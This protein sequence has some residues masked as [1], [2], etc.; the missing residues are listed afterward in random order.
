[1]KQIREM[2]YRAA[3]IGCGVIGSSIDEGKEHVMGIQSHAAAYQACARTELVGVCDVDSVRTAA[4]AKIRCVSKHYNDYRIL[5][6]SCVPDVVSIATETATHD[7]ILRD[8]LAFPSVK[9]VIC[10][11]PIASNSI[12]ATQLV[13][14][15]DTTGCRLVV[16]YSRHYL[17]AMEQIRK[18][19]IGRRIGKIRLVN[20]YYT[21]SLVHN[22]THLLELLRWWFGDLRLV[23]S[24][25]AVW[26]DSCPEYCDVLFKLHGGEPVYLHALDS[27]DYSLFEIDIIGSTGRISVTKGGDLVSTWEVKEHSL[28]EGYREFAPIPRIAKNCLN[29]LMLSVVDTALDMLEGDEEATERCCFGKDAVAVLQLAEDVMQALQVRTLE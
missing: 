1:M 11:K 19:I 18:H 15:A 3:L 9:L 28:F 8:V 29:D 6:E 7:Q 22:G 25:S 12:L 17:P 20:G 2:R 27:R 16:N 10:E 24:A 4:C 26:A 23:H 14:I 21:K 13:A 5:L